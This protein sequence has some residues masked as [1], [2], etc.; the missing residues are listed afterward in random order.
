MSGKARTEGVAIVGMSCRFHGAN[1]PAELW[2]HLAAGTE[3]IDR[4][5][6]E[7]L[8]AVGEPA[9]AIRNPAYVRASGFVEGIDQCDARF[10]GL[11]PTEAEIID[12]QVRVFLECSWEAL[13]DAC[14]VPGQ[15]AGRIGVVGG[16]GLNHYYENNLLQS[17]IQRTIGPL[18]IHVANDDDYVATRVSYALNL[19][20]PSLTVQ[21]ACSTSLVAVCLGSQS[22]LTYESDLML[23]G[24]VYLKLRHSG[25]WYEEGSL[26]SPDGHCRSFDA[27]ARGTVFNSGVGVVA[28]KRLSDAVADRNRIYAVIRG[29]ATN[30]DGSAKVGFT[31]PGVNGQAEVIRD[32]LS[33]AAVHPD[34]IGYVEAHGTGTELGDPIEVAALS[35]AFREHTSKTGYCALGSLKSNLG[36]TNTAAGVAG[37]IKAALTLERGIIPPHLHFETPNP[38]IDFGNS[39]FFVNTTPVPWATNGHPRCAAVSSFGVGGTNAH[40]VLEEAPSPEIPEEAA[41]P[42]LLVISAASDTALEAA[43]DRL[44][45]FLRDTPEVRLGDVAASLRRGRKAFDWR[46]AVVVGSREEAVAALESRDGQ[47]PFAGTPE[48]PVVFMFPGQGSQ[49]VGMARALDQR[50]AVF[51]EQFDRCSELLRPHLHLPGTFDLRR[52]VHPATAEEA[53]QAE[54]LL[55][56]TYV[57]QPALF[58]L[59]YAL[60][61]QWMAWGIQPHAM[62]GHS[63][64]EYVA[65][66][67]AGV[68]TLE[69]ALAVVA[70]RGRLMQTMPPGAMLAVMMPA[71]EVAPFLTD[72]V[73]IAAVNAPALTVVAGSHAAIDALDTALQERGMGTRRLHTSHAFHSA[74]MDPILDQFRDVVARVQRHAPQRRFLSN[75]TGTWIRDDEAT[76]PAYWVRHLRSTVRFADNV[77]EVLMDPATVL[78]EVGAGVTL[79]S[80]VRQH[81]EDG[82]QRRIASSLPPATAAGADLSYA[83]NALGELW[84]AGVAPDWNAYQAAIGP[85]RFVSMPTYPF[86]RERFWIDPQ[87]RTRETPR[88][89]ISKL[90]HIDDWFYVPA[91]RRSPPAEL[92]GAGTDAPTWLFFED[93]S[94]VVAGMADDVAGAGRDVITVSA[95][96]EFRRLTDT[97]MTVN[98]GSAQD[99][100][101]LISAVGVPSGAPLHIVYG[102]T[103]DPLADR[104]PEEQRDYAFHALL[105]LTQALGQRDTSGG[106]RIDVLSSAVCDVTGDDPLEPMKAVVLGACRTIPQEYPTIQCRHVDVVPP[107]TDDARRT[108]VRVLVQEC[109]SRQVAAMVAYRGSHRWTLTVPAV[110]LPPAERTP[111]RERG[112]YLVTGGHGGMGTKIAKYLAEAAHARLALVSRSA[113]PEREQWDAWLQEHDEGDATSETIRA[114]RECE[115][116]GAEVL[117]LRADVASEADLERAIARIRQ[118]WGTVNGVF[119]TAGTEGNGLIP[120]KT[121]E[122]AEQTFSSKITG[123]LLLERLLADQPLDCFVLFSSLVAITGNV[124]QIDYCAANAF[125]DAFA[126]DRARRGGTRV[127]SINWDGWSDVGMMA[128]LVRSRRGPAADPAASGRPFERTAGSEGAVYQGALS[129]GTDW[130]VGDHRLLGR[131]TLVGT[132]YLELARAAAQDDDRRPIELSD[133]LLLSPLMVQEGHVVEIEATAQQGN[134]ASDVA[135]RSRLAM[136]RD[137]HG[138]WQD[139]AVAT[140]RGADRTPRRVDL[141]SI[142]SRCGPAAG[143]DVPLMQLP[144]LKGTQINLGPRWSQCR[145]EFRPGTGEAFSRIT[146]PDEFLPDLERFA[147]HP[148]MLDLAI[149]IAAVR[150]QTAAGLPA[151]ALPF[152]YGRVTVFGRFGR[153]ICS[154]LRLQS[155]PTGDLV[156]IEAVITDEEGNELVAIDEFTM[157]RATAAQQRALSSKPAGPD[158]GAALFMSPAEGI[159][160][161][162]RVLSYPQLG[163]VVVSTA[164]LDRRGARTKPTA[165]KGVGKRA[166]KDG[167]NARKASHPRPALKVAYVAPGNE[168]ETTLAE[169]WQSLLGIE[170]IGVND[171]F[172]ELG[173]NS[174]LGVQVAARVRETFRMMLPIQEFFKAPTIAAL[175]ELVTQRLIASAD[176]TILQQMLDDIEKSSAPPAAGAD[177]GSATAVISR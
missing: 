28:L 41:G 77:T 67:L 163:Q 47:G 97:Q 3:L 102:W 175:A 128:R 149:S 134:A 81:S 131:P 35:K 29:F 49:Y 20:G 171:G 112:V 103:L 80:L 16:R 144:G 59:E 78:L 65:A 66:C 139:R 119:H 37:L 140:A 136:G 117:P 27:R 126:N 85:A 46:R 106:V 69:D 129:P 86:E 62:V 104:S 169:I 160:V 151:D 9:E 146:L 91:W 10:F 158:P 18:A 150:L 93:A 148:A 109:R 125:L 156:S 176:A 79:Q 57:T 143:E 1:T 155:D 33:M 142:A 84:V 105:F 110:P 111:L 5:S 99:F 101:S 152:S 44:A 141:E 21:T 88:A 23:C 60:A 50:F 19:T 52:L 82:R 40:V 168:L 164:P 17:S 170:K 74:M 38:A 15:F 39:P 100:E 34:D 154:H 72:E 120:L 8:L 162:A 118:Q 76:D 55:V 48:P 98:P 56:Q 73:S 133:V 122:A 7:Q 166:G 30:N 174:L 137:G 92:N 161:L 68:F 132:A 172:F 31:A 167:G 90:P 121:K 95:G 70:A 114:L 123:T 11:N 22:L 53:G 36:H 83:L 165:D 14:C 157:K 130:V 153:T 26:M 64:G 6:E 124:G 138:P 51:H 12:P 159:Q 58:A 116:L 61:Q 89:D 43:A 4:L 24:G 173:G 25:Y 96:N 75:L 113:F 32:A 2:R 107:A 13:E 54:D 108:L 177:A 145:W 135:I 63:I 94:G 87:P 127:V 147:I 45:A 42:H 115:E 71:D